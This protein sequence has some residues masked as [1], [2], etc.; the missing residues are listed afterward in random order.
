[1]IVSYDRR[2]NLLVVCTV[3]LFTYRCAQSTVLGTGDGELA[4]ALGELGAALGHSSKSGTHVSYNVSSDVQWTW[5]KDE[6]L[7]VDLGVTAW[8]STSIL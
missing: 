1:M 3:S 8:W 4:A 6:P 7:E 5:L 2:W